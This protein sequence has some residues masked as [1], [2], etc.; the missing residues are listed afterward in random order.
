YLPFLWWS[1][2]V[3]TTFT[4]VAKHQI[5]TQ[6]YQ[7]QLSHESKAVI[8]KIVNKFINQ[9][10]SLNSL[11]TQGVLLINLLLLTAW[12]FIRLIIRQKNNL[13][14]VLLAL[15]LS[16]VVYYLSVLAM[17][18]VSMPYQEAIQ[19]DGSERYLA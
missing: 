3:K 2:H 6:A 15:D 8:L 10:V 17:Y 13:G 4:K 11:S 16:F 19:L 18:L 7:Q 5:S 9:I 1:W 12:L 14:Q